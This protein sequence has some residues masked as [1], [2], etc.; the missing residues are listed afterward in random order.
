MPLF[1]YIS[2]FCSQQTLSSFKISLL[3]YTTPWHYP[4]GKYCQKIKRKWKW[5]TFLQYVMIRYYFS[6]V[7][8]IV[9]LF[10]VSTEP[11]TLCWPSHKQLFENN[12]IKTMEFQNRSSTFNLFKQSN[13]ILNLV[14][15][16]GNWCDC[17]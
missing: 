13:W 9:V 14:R 3:V 8:L 17:I 7:L 12:D 15:A 4:C 1:T 16:Y 6:A 10:T 11:S 5:F 2:L